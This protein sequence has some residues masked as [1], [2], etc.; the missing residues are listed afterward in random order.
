[1]LLSLF[2]L[3]RWMWNGLCCCG[4]VYL[5]GDVSG[6]LEVRLGWRGR[7]ECRVFMSLY[8]S[9]SSRRRDAVCS[10]QVRMVRGD[11]VF[12]LGCEVREEIH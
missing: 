11:G 7:E 8:S 2:Q 3:L 10:V 1:M 5:H 12:A 4:I 6:R 9:S